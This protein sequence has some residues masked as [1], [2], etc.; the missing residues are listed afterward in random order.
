MPIVPGPHTSWV[1]RTSTFTQTF[2][3]GATRIL[4]ECLARIFSVIV[5]PGI[6]K[7]L[8]IL[9]STSMASSI[10]LA[11]QRLHEQRGADRDQ[12]HV[13]EAGERSPLQPAVDLPAEHDRDQRR[14]QRPQIIARD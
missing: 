4:P 2:S 8:S 5:M 13:N 6:F 11:T 14:G 7:L 9:S 1:I 3:S 10:S 12:P